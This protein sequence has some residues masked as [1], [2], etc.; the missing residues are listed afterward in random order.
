MSISAE[1]SIRE[2]W[3]SLPKSKTVL[4]VRLLLVGILAIG[5]AEFSLYPILRGF[6]VSVAKNSEV[7]AAN[8]VV[9]EL[10][11]T[12]ISTQRDD[13]NLQPISAILGPQYAGWTG[14]VVVWE[15]FGV[16]NP[17]NFVINATWSI[18]FY[19]QTVSGAT[20]DYESFQLGANKGSVV[21]IR[22]F[23][24]GD[25]IG[26][27]YGDWRNYS[28]TLGAIYIAVGTYGSYELS[29]YSTYD[30]WRNIGNGILDSTASLP[31]C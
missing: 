26:D 18:R 12:C 14:Y 27:R 21:A 6:A 7:N 31:K 19:F 10:R 8:R 29:Q 13:S 20:G 16:Y 3:L 1:P 9:D 4:V 2:S 23:I 28:A 25:Q 22:L 11:L 30:S 5:V 17:T 15:T 24:P